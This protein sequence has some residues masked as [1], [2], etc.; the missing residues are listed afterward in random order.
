MGLTAMT[1]T[2]QTIK[3]KAR[4]PLITH[5]A[6]SVVSYFRCRLSS[7]SSCIWL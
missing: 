5:K 2:C 6:P 4:I 7:A 1:N 3:Y